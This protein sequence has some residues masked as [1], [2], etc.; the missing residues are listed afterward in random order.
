MNRDLPSRLW[1]R[2]RP[3]SVRARLVATYTLV[4]LV[5]AAGGFALFAMLLDRGITASMDATLQTRIAPLVNS[6]ASSTQGAPL[7]T[8]L[9]PS[10]PSLAADPAALARGTTGG[11]QAAAG[12][13]SCSLW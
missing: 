5:L 10:L 13:E 1:R 8:G 6:V 7:E 12:I 9:A 4:A 2:W 3:R 11:Q